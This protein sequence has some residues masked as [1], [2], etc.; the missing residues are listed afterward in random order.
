MSAAA[1]RFDDLAA[2]LR[3]LAPVVDWPATP[4]LVDTLQERLA[5][6]RPARRRGPL[7][8][9]IAALVVGGAVA[10]SPAGSA[11]LDALGVS[12]GEEITRVD[13]T[14]TITVPSSPPSTQVPRFGPG[15]ATTLPAAR[16]AAGFTARVPTLLGAPDEVRFSRAVPGGIVTLVYRDADVVLTQFRGGATP[17]VQKQIGP[18][19]SVRRAEVGGAPA[20]FLTGGQSFVV[21]QDADG[22]VVEGTAALSGGNVLVWDDAR[23]VAHRLELRGGR[24]RALEI[25]RS[26]R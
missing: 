5:P 26:L 8:A 19:T 6:R 1:D 13:T 11:L 25:A 9:A 7:L 24:E 10:V 4:D 21:V 17:Y 20:A 16:A 14:P 22:R 18:Q 2:E 3:A 23:G 15:A 12:G